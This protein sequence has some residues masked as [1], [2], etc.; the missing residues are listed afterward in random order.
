M[1]T[2]SW[3]QPRFERL[4]TLWSSTLPAK[5]IAETL[6]VEFPDARPLS[7]HAVMNKARAA[8][9]PER[10]R[11]HIEAKPKRPIAH[12]GDGFHALRQGE[13]EAPQFFENEALPPNQRKRLVDLQHDECRWPS[14][15]VDGFFFCAATVVDAGSPYCSR[16]HRRAH[17]GR[18]QLTSDEIEQLTA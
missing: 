2:E 12:M 16:H 8:D 18:P 4:T 5:E 14:E 15:T 10:P 9:L 1:Q 17:V 7:H 3:P 6:T 11:K 13:K